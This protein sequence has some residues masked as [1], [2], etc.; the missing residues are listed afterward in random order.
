MARIIR[1]MSSILKNAGKVIEIACNGFA[2]LMSN[3]VSYLRYTES[4]LEDYGITGM[5]V[6]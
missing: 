3:D 5:L 4:I 6:N 2:V 1:K